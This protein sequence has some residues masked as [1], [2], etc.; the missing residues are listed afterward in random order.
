MGLSMIGQVNQLELY[1]CNFCSTLS[2]WYE[3]IWKCLSTISVPLKRRS[4]IQNIKYPA[5]GTNKINKKLV[6]NFCSWLKNAWFCSFS[7]CL[8]KNKMNTTN[9][10]LINQKPNPFHFMEKVKP[11]RKLP[12]RRRGK[13]PFPLK[14]WSK[15]RTDN[16]QM[17][18]EEKIVYLS[19]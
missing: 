16:F 13:L 8:F 3:A 9:N 7:H 15:K 14:Y 18:L 17:I 11:N 5:K 12:I 1:G 10:I 6:L 19:I 4:G 2:V